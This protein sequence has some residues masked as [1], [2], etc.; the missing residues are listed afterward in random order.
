M[1]KRV[2]VMMAVSLL[3]CSLT[4]ADLPAVPICTA[5]G[6]QVQPD[7]DGRWIVWHDNRNGTANDDIYGYILSEPNE[8]PICTVG[9]HQ[10]YPKVS[11]SIVVWQD[12]RSGQRDIYAF[13]LQNRLPLELVGMPLSD[14]IQQRYPKISGSYI[15]Y[16]HL[17]D[18]LFNLFLYNLSAGTVSPVSL[19]SYKQLNSAVDGSIAV[20]MEDRGPVFQVYYCDFSR[21]DPAVPVSPSNFAQWYPAVSGSVVVWAEDRGLGTGLDIYGFDLSQG[22]EFSIC[23]ASGEQNHPD[24]S[25]RLVVWQDA[26]K[27]TSDMD[28]WAFD[29]DKGTLFPIATDGNNDQ[30]PAVSGCRA[31]WQRGNS[32]NFDIYMAQIPSPRSIAILSP[33]AG[34]QILA[35]SAVQIVWQILEGSLPDE[36]KIEFSTDNGNN[37]QLIESA[38][39]ADVPYQWQTPAGVDSLNCLIRISDPAAPE[40][41]VVSGL[42]TVFRCSAALTAD[43]TGDCFVGL[44]DVAQLA[45]Q[46][47]I[48]GNPYNPNWCG[49]H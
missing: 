10:R 44:D 28:I 34:Q 29:L 7:I 3:V 47:L 4:E 12:D 21:S 40:V 9:G 46:W 11:G 19:S 26:S 24:I 33:A 39:P 15:L 31:V 38:V 13:D 42:F 2:M 37:W 30:Y 49:S 43:I 6:D 20:W 45:S 36:I 17:T 1:H 48:C 14:G 16:E 8:L 23:T 5:A 25:G 35:G 27:G 32:G 22:R 18:G 41:A